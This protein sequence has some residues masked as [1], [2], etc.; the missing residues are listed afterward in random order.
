MTE[1]LIAVTIPAY[2]AERALATAARS[3]LRQSL[4]DLEVWIVDDGSVDRTAEIA[5]R[6]ARE[7]SRVRV[8]HQPNHGAYMAR[9]RALRQINTPYFG[10]LDADDRAEPEMYGKM[11]EWAETENLDVVQCCPCGARA[12]DGT[13][14]VLKGREDVVRHLIKPV[15]LEGQGATF[16][17][18]KIYR[19]RYDFDLFENAPITMFDDML[20][21]LQAFGVVCRVGLLNEGLY[22]YQINDGS[23]VRN[24]KAKNLQ[25]FLYVVR[26]RAGLIGKYGI[27]Y[28][29]LE[30]HRWTVLN[31]RNL[32]FVVVSAPNM[33][34]RARLAGLRAIVGAPEVVEAHKAVTKARKRSSSIIWLGF[35]MGY[36][37]FF[38]VCGLALK[39]GV[40]VLRRT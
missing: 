14:V 8:L 12:A 24:Y 2:N 30:H 9:L 3:V 15:L 4:R 28:T 25:D 18:D 20:F 21:N 19:N 32:L 34:F 26:Y 35:A 29:P 11:L 17:W 33:A 38:L 7:D 6:L 36:P 13:R 27:W 23:S 22:H 31:A 40:R 39:L 5:D 10:F 37:H 1:A 16:M